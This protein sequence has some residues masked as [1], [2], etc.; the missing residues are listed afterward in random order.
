MI[1]LIFLR[2]N[3]RL[4]SFGV[5]M[6]FLSSA[7]QTFFISLFGGEIRAEFSLSHGEFGSIYSA[8]T[9]VSAALLI[10]GGVLIDRMDLARYC[11]GVLIGLAAACV[12]VWFA[13]NALWLGVAIFGL[14]FFGQGLTSH[15]AI[16]TMARFF[17]AERGRAISIAS[18]GYTIGEAVLPAIV[19]AALAVMAWHGAWLAAAGFLILAIP[20]VVWLLAS[21]NARAAASAEHNR[22]DSAIRRDSTLSEA[23]RDIG[24]WLRIPALLAPSFLFTG[25]IFHQIHLAEEK[26]WP[27]LDLATAYSL[28]AVTAVFATLAGGILIDRVSATRLVPV[29]LL[30]LALSCLSLVFV[31]AWYGVYVFLGVLGLSSG[32]TLVMLGALWA[33]L[34]GVTHLGTIKAF[35]QAAMVFSTGLAPG[36]MGLLIDAGYTM[37]WIGGAGAAYCVAASA[38]SLLARRPA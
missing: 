17:R 18:L 9:L 23:L 26:A 32:I 21:G 22:A 10:W 8:A 1:P 13:P 2:Q 12:I 25:L 27:V 15:A 7:G 35:G 4:L 38:L 6:S 29:F 24:L 33:E 20:V 37:A 19:V 36:A 34:Y 16:T 5:F 31:D 14:R 28:Y 11:T 3:A 30:P